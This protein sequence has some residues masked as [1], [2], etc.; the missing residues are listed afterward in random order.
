MPH[1]DGTREAK[2][3]MRFANLFGEEFECCIQGRARGHRNNIV[4]PGLVKMNGAGLP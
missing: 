4:P 1:E 3:G 2:R